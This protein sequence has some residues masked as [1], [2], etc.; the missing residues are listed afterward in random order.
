MNTNAVLKAKT[1]VKHV[2]KCLEYNILF[3]MY[4]LI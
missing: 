2:Q 3:K 4:A 1:Y